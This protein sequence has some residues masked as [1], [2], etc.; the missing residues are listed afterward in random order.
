MSAFPPL[1]GVDRT[2]VDQL[3]MGKRVHAHSRLTFESRASQIHLGTPV[4]ES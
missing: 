2:S 4:R 1:S 3:L